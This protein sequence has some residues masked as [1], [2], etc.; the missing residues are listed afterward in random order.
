MEYSDIDAAL[1]KLGHTMY[2]SA[3]IN[4]E[5]LVQSAVSLEDAM[6][7]ARFHNFVANVQQLRVYLGM[8]GGQSHMTMIH[9]PG[10]YYSIK[11]SMSA[12]QGKIMAFIGNCRA[13]KEPTLMCLPLTQ[14]WEW[15]TGNAIADVTKVEAYYAVEANKGTLWMPGANDGP[16]STVPVPNLLAIPNALVNLLCTPGQAITPH[17][18]LVTVDNFIQSSRHP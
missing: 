9:T 16:P 1:Q 17:D 8:L 13:S 12:Y 14:S 18:V 6:L 11:S 5:L 15:H 3:T 10:I 4:A 2:D 7:C